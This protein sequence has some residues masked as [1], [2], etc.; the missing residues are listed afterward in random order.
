MQYLLIQDIQSTFIFIIK[1]NWIE[2][3]EKMNEQIENLRKEV[4]YFNYILI[5]SIQYAWNLLFD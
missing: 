1:V 2:D 5:K 3:V 4:C